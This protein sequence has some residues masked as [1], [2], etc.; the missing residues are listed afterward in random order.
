MSVIRIPYDR[1][2]PYNDLP[3]LPP[4]DAKIIDMEIMAKLANARGA[5]GKLDGIV[6]TLPNPE[7]LVNTITL[8]EAKDSSEIEN[9]F[10]S[11]DELYQALAIETTEMP[12][13]A[14]EVLRYRQALE[15]GFATMK[16]NN[17]IDMPTVLAIF[18]KIEDTT[19]SIRPPTLT[20]V[21]KK[22]G[23]SMTSGQTIYTPP[24]GKGIIEGKMNNWLEYC[25]NDK[26]FGYDALIKMA[27]THYQFEAIHPFPD[28][29]GRTG[30]IL[31]LLLLS[32]KGLLTYPVL[33]LSGYIIRNK[34]EYYEKIG[35]VTE[36]FSWKPWI[37]FILEGV[38]QTSYYTINLIERINE[39]YESTKAF[40]LEE[41][42]KFNQEIIKLLF[43][44]PYI[45]AVNIANTPACR[46]ASRQTADKKLME[47]F[48]I[49]MV[50]K[51]Q[52]GRE[53]VY[54]NHQLISL[55]SEKTDKV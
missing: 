14:R 15:I 34:N 2:K 26:D 49:N 23:S 37:M 42:P 46:I 17:K 31:N 6:R 39:L 45:R 30:R 10:T 54:I 55:L 28:G 47:L 38:E 18:Q 29:N 3:L 52:V 36:R 40:I 7:M 35:A 27:V 51:K 16:A 33:Y 22:G 32:Q 48:T 4:P 43:F 1:N 25:N 53:T 41:N 20:T 13:S 5:I 21:I 50:S 9:I 44:Q 8:R 12:A 11:N 19:Q 24:R